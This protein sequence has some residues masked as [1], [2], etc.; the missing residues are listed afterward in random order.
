MTM[1]VDE[2][3]T[4][5]LRVGFGEPA[6]SDQ[7]VRDVA[8]CVE[9]LIGGGRITGG[10]LLKINGPIS[11]IAAMVLCHAVAHRYEAISMFDPKLN[12]YVVTISH[13]PSYRVGDLIA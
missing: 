5:L 7:I 9:E 12:R 13:G 10:P 1:E 11:V 6:Q 8:L 3:G 2:A 4:P